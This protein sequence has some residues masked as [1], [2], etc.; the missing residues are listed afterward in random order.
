MPDNSTK[1]EAI[2]EA[3]NSGALSVTVDGQSV[4]YRS[5]AEMR[6]VRKQLVVDDTSG[7]YATQK[8]RRPVAARIKLSGVLS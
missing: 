6:Q 7:N 2:D 8:R 3:I 5:L 1:I 4:R